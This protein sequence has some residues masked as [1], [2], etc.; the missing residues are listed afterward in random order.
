MSANTSMS[1]AQAPAAPVPA[2]ATAG[3]VVVG[4][5]GSPA[6][7]LALGWA[8][9]EAVLRGVG[10]RVVE[11]APPVAAAML[12]T[13]QGAAAVQTEREAALA[14]L[15][16]L[17]TDARAAADA[18][19][20]A[21]DIDVPRGSPVDVLAAEARDAG[22]L[23]VGTRGRGPAREAVLGSVSEGCL[24]AVACPV[25]VVPPGA[26]ARGRVGR[27]VVG[28]DGSAGAWNALR[29]AEDE[30][31][32][33]QVELL[34]VHAWHPPFVITN[35]Y[36]PTG[37]SVEL[38]RRAGQEVLDAGIAAVDGALHAKGELVEGRASGA[39]VAFP[40]DL[41]VV[42]GR[43]L[44]PLR[45]ALLGSVSQACARHAHCPVVVVR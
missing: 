45:G 41:L 16:R 42:G 8:L 7:V 25:V 36:V 27:I 21:V 4:V 9:E 35:P 39:L 17:V 37:P 13:S 31:I 32:R 34:V 24:G 11:A 1:P 19:R 33:R 23:V 22:L 43:G 2:P 26:T 44:G 10:C 38:S 6:S 40:A 5:D 30:A 29:W 12:T 15:D 18:W 14:T 3:P 28:F 20:V